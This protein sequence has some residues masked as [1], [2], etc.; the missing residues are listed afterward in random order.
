MKNK[1]EVL[2]GAIDSTVKIIDWTPINRII[3]KSVGCEVECRMGNGLFLNVNA[4]FKDDYDEE[5]QHIITDTECCG[6]ST[7]NKN[8]FSLDLNEGKPYNY[9]IFEGVGFYKVYPSK[10]DGSKSVAMFPT[11]YFDIDSADVIKCLTGEEK[12]LF[13]F[14][15]SRYNY[16]PRIRNNEFAMLKLVY[17]QHIKHG[18]KDWKNTIEKEVES[19]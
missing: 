18:F 1:K 3:S 12:S 14:M 2:L 8:I 9:K 10:E 4:V 16:N 15:G 13:E 19:V 7:V 11:Y 6:S 17:F 5:I